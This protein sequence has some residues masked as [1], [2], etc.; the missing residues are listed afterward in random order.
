MKSFSIC[1]KVLEKGIWLGVQI[2]Q[3]VCII[4]IKHRSYSQCNRNRLDSVSQ[5]FPSP[6]V[7]LSTKSFCCFGKKKKRKKTK[8]LCVCD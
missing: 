3:T 7:I 6:L 1:Y 2:E 8:H 5:F 4:H